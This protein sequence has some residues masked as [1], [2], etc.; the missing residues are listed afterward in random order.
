MDSVIAACLT[1]AIMGGVGLFALQ[2]EIANTRVQA[3]PVKPLVV[4]TSNNMYSDYILAVNRACVAALDEVEASMSEEARESVPL[5][6][7]QSVYSRCMI[8]HNA[9]I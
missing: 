6:V 1:G 7:W 4:A 3:E 8:N 9:T 5:E 2:T